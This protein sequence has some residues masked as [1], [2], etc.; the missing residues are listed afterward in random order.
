MKFVIMDDD[1]LSRVMM[2]SRE[3]V[4]NINQQ[5]WCWEIGSGSTGI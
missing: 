1:I 2:L 4:M 3:L 5:F